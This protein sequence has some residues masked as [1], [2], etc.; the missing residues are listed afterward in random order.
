TL[1]EYPYELDEEGKRKGFLSAY[2]QEHVDLVNAIRTDTP[3]NEGENVATSTM[4][5]IMGRIS[6]YTGKETTWDEMMNT[7]LK[8]A[9]KVYAMG[10]VDVVKEVPVPGEAWKPKA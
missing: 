8:L 10:D 9:P 7:D 1:W 4:V 2:V 3:I 5:A 6:A